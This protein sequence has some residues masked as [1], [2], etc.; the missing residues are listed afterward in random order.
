MNNSTE[1]FEKLR[2]LLT[3]KR[4]ESPPPGYFNGFST[5]VL[6]RIE[7]EQERR[8]RS[9]SG[10]LFPWFRAFLRMF[11]QNPI[12][13][14]IL[15]VG[16]CGL[17]FSGYALSQYLDKPDAADVA[18]FGGGV[19]NTGLNHAA[20]VMDDKSQGGTTLGDSITPI[21]NTNNA[22]ALFSAPSG[23]STLP[24]SYNFSH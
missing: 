19:P 7:R 24:V 17:V 3:L 15:G 10:S 2:K 9:P 12:A 8:F 21:F 14:G 23:L 20:L 1:D 6:N 16:A 18:A 22:S 5:R 4:H 13:S 11:E